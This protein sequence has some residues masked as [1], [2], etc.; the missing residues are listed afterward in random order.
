MH[1]ALKVK[2]AL[3]EIFPETF[4][5]RFACISVY[6]CLEV[7]ALAGTPINHWLSDSTFC[8]WAH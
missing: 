3:L 2:L 5:Y 1:K 7:Y 8:T 4:H 6:F